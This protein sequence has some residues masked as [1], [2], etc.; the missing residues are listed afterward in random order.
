MDEGKPAYHD[1]VFDN[2]LQ[3]FV[4]SEFEA[5]WQYREIFECGCYSNI[6]LPDAPVVIDVGANIGLF[7][8]FMKQ[9]R[10][11]ASILAFEPISPVFQVLTEN[12]K[13]SLFHN[14]ALYQY[15][16]GSHDEEDVE[17]TYYPMLP[18]NSTRFPNEKE[19][20]IEVM[21]R[22]QATAEVRALHHGIPMFADC[23]TLSNFIGDHQM[24]DL[25]KIDVEG[26]ELEVLNGIRPDHWTKIDQVVIEVQDMDNRL[27]KIRT[28]L[29]KQKFVVDIQP[30]P[31]INP[32][33][34]TF[35]LYGGKA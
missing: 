9:L 23:R 17:F 30:A 16:L 32:D 25:L 1:V 4:I 35:L 24:I 20:Q 19:L 8:I 22:E 29:E 3:C 10:P 6:R 7:T 11:A 21:A 26:S 34:R 33:I 13:R 2:G 27:E 18:G 5:T 12:V 14:V 28:V 15:A 31:M